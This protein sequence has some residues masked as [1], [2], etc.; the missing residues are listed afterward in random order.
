MVVVLA[1]GVGHRELIRRLLLL[2]V[3]L[4]VPLLGG[5]LGPVPRRIRRMDATLER[6]GPGRGQRGWGRC[7][8][9]RRRRCS[10]SQP[11]SRSAH[12]TGQAGRSGHTAEAAPHRGR[13]HRL[14]LEV[15]VDG[16]ATE[17]SRRAR[18]ADRGRP[19]TEGRR[20]VR[21]VVQRA[22]DAVEVVDAEKMNE[23][24]TKRV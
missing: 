14:V 15:L 16:V 7:R 24:Q 4:L 22:L 11:R 20:A 18:P 13:G 6:A 23:K 10:N 17:R 9:L 3:L 1:G 19:I 21:R 8:G 12:R 2:L 5:Y